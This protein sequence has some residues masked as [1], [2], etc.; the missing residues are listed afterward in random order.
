MRYHEIK[1][2]P[3][4]TDIPSL[5]D[6]LTAIGFDAFELSDGGLPEPGGWDYID[7]SLVEKQSDA[8]FIRLYFEDNADFP[9]LYVKMKRS[10]YD[11]ADS[12]EAV[13]FEESVHDDSEWK[14]VWKQYFKPFTAG[15]HIVICPKW[16]I[17]HPKPEDIVVIIDPGAAFGSGLHETTRMCIAALEKHVS[18]GA[19]VIDVG[20]GS[21]I[22]G[23]AAAK[24]GADSVW[25]LDYDPASV[26]SANENARLNGVAIHVAQSDLMAGAPEIKADVIVANIVA[27]IIIRLN[28]TI[29][30]YLAEDGIYIM[31]G[32]IAERLS[33][34][35][36][37]LEQQG[38][39]VHTVDKMGEWRA[40]TASRKHA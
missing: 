17:Y 1:L 30:D 40:V 6:A 24:L 2:I 20:C 19:S 18:S 14:D 35:L 27:D 11:W 39:T 13:T 32:I 37:S 33:D 36:E 22:L 38:F 23:I 10:V 28:Q 7:E 25:A 3:N 15:E 21:G 8:P 9:Q 16:E 5:A 34:V 31:S 29:R 4:N 26:T 12:D